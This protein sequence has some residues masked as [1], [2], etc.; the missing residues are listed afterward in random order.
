ML[1]IRKLRPF[2][3]NARDNQR[4]NSHGYGFLEEWRHFQQRCD[5]SLD[6]LL[7]VRT[8]DGRLHA[9]LSAK[10][11]LLIKL[12]ERHVCFDLRQTGDR[13]NGFN[14]SQTGKDFKKE[15]KRERWLKNGQKKSGNKETGRKS[16]GEL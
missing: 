11:S 10:D 6:V 5:Q 9:C 1:C 4:L 2:D 3:L 14:F 15:K 7:N 12:D 8:L 13:F 16:L